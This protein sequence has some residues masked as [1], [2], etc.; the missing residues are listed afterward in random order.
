MQYFLLRFAEIQSVPFSD[1]ARCI[2]HLEF[3]SPGASCA[4]ILKLPFVLDQG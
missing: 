1:A 2:L 3:A 4:L